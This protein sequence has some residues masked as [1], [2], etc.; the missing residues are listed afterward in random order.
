MDVSLILTH[1]CNL[2]CGYCYAGEHYRKDMDDETLERAVDLLLADDA[3][4]AQLSFF[5]GEPFLA[6]NS[7]QRAV[8]LAETR[9]GARGRRL[10]LQCTTNGTALK[11]EHV[12]FVVEHDIRTTVSIDGVREAHDLNRPCAG[13][14]SSFDQTRD[15]LRKLIEAGCKPDAMMVISPQTVPYVYS[16]VSFLWAEGVS[17]VRANMVLDA[18]WTAEDRAELRE[19]LLSVGWEM[20]ARRTRG[21][22]ATFEPFEKGMRRGTRFARRPPNAKRSQVTVAA[23]GFL[24]PC[25]PMVGEDR[26]TGQE[27]ALRIGHLDDGREQ[28]IDRVGCDGVACSTGGACD[29]ASYLETGDR[30]TPGPNGRWYAA[31]CAELGVAI[32]AALTAN[33]YPPRHEEPSR[34]PFLFGM[35]AA[36]GGLAIGVPALLRA[37]FFGGDKPGC[38]AGPSRGVL[39]PI[40]IPEERLQPPGQLMAPEPPPPEPPPELEIHT[41]GDIAAPEPEIQVDGDMAAPEPPPEPPPER[42]VHTR[43]KMAPPDPEPMIVGEFG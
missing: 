36:V 9:T 27:A 14:G 40:D 12:D 22:Q 5:G 15:G 42:E 30:K 17:T 34:R 1:R 43:G 28:I 11:Q 3:D 7:M 32:M 35:A 39:D 18:P 21:E 10:I 38:D 33:H 37:G 8:A 23:T 41:K 6:F 24:Y 29:C 19:Q 20:L 4:T 25:S 31:V 13:G 2:D 26:E 16:S